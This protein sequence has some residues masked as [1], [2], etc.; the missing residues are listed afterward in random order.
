MTLLTEKEARL[1]T[2]PF[3]RYCFN[4]DGVLHNN[5]T[6]IYVHQNCRASD[7]KIGWRTEHDADFSEVGEE[8]PQGY[9]GAFGAPRP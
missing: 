2:C 6:P 3:I 8:P 9:C 7:C 4:E 1:Q 5:A